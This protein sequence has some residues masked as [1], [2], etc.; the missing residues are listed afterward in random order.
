M[1]SNYT[2]RKKA[3]NDLDEILDY[4]AQD[5]PKAALELY[6]TFLKQFEL[7]SLFPESGRLRK[8]FSPAVR[9]LAVGYYIIFFAE[10]NPVEIVRVLHGARDIPADIEEM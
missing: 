7:L 4:I 1:E 10:K 5:N 3:E 2:L 8:E 9:S 6:E